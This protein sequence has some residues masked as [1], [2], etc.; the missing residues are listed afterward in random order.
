MATGEN[1]SDG[2]GRRTTI[3]GAGDCK[4][5]PE[6]LEY[7]GQMGEASFHRCSACDGALVSW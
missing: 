3:G 5:P 7:L 6:A 4:H 2:S 1:Y